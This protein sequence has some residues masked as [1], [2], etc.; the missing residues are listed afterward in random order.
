MKDIRDFKKIVI[1]TMPRSGTVFLF[2]FMSRLTGFEKVE[3]KFTGG[4]SPEPPEWDPYKF[5]RTYLELDESEIITAHYP[6][7]DDMAE[8]I[9]SSDVLPIY[10]YRDPRD[11]AVSATLYIKNVLTHHCL[12]DLFNSIS[13]SDALLFTLCGGIVNVDN[14]SCSNNYI[15]HDGMKYFL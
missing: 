5:D 7:N 10:L 8:M 13:D 15:R 6:L 4:F 9:N 3:P 2:Q 14:D 1:S 12:H 11:A